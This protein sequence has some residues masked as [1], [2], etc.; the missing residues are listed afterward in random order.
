MNVRMFVNV[1]PAGYVD[2][3]GPQAVEAIDVD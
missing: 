3:I 2:G 1:A